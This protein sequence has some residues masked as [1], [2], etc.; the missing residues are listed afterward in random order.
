M[1]LKISPSKNSARSAAT[2]RVRL[3]RSS[4][5]V[6]RMPSIA[7]L[8]WNESRIRST[9]SMSCEIPSSAKNSH[10]MGMRTESEATKAFSVSRSSAGGQSIMM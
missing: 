5:I 10:W 1:V 6:S 2:C 8:C 7:R 4:Y 3:V 9:V